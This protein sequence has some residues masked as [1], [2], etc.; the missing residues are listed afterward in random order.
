[1]ELI[2]EEMELDNFPKL[3]NETQTTDL[4]NIT[5]PSWMNSMDT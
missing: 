1:M 4:Q 2:L 5:I 3:I